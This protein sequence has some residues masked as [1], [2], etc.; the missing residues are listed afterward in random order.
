MSP[1]STK[2]QTT[3]RGQI[4]LTV[5]RK[6]GDLLGLAD[7]DIVWRVRS[8]D[9]L[10]MT[11]VDDPEQ[12]RTNRVTQRNDTGQYIVTISP[13]L[14]E[15]MRLRDAEVSWH[16]HSRDSLDVVIETRGGGEQ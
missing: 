7:A 9:R 5:P 1:K 14:A 13:G 8:A 6:K 4:R 15:A 16:D 12:H 11:R 3:S 10:R 2:V